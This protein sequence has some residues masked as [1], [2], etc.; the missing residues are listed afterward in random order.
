M[1]KRHG[2]ICE[3]TVLQQ[4]IQ[5]E[6]LRSSEDYTLCAFDVELCFIALGT[7]IVL[8]FPQIIFSRFFFAFTL[9]S[10][11]GYADI[12]YLISYFK[13]IIVHSISY[14]VYEYNS[15]TLFKIYLKH[16]TKSLTS[17]E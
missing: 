8:I 14:L 1:Y 9:F 2:Y 3:A 13:G 7:C 4:F 17:W 11:Y 15:N 6:S 16:H 12:L 5:S 10:F